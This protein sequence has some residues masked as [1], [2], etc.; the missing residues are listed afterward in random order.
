M[1][2]SARVSFIL[3]F[4]LLTLHALAQDSYLFIDG[5]LEDAT[6]TNDT[7]NSGGTLVVNGHTMTVPLNVLVQFPSA[8]IPFKDFVAAKGNFIGLEV[9]VSIA[10]SGTL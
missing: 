8:W 2:S 3:G 10:K 1:F 4:F 9:F 6:A 5:F 7:Y